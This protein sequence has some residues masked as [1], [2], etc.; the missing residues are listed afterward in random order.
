MSAA[1]SA[2]SKQQV[3]VH[4]TAVAI[5]RVGALLL[6]PSGSG[7]SD[8]ALRV[9]EAGGRLIAD[10]QVVLS[11]VGEKLIAN[12]PTT[13]AGRIEARG[14]GIL[15][16]GGAQLWRKMPVRLAVE[17]VPPDRV[18]RLPEPAT[19]EF[20]GFALPLIRLAPFE[21]SAIAKLRLAARYLKQI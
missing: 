1:D 10:D 8:L 19:R 7:K 4:A 5:D 2:A 15:S 17:L 16:L 3:F 18:E 6:G 21:V 20:L 12:A 13:L 11:R 14:I 9:L